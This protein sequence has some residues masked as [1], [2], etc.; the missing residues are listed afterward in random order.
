MKAFGS[1]WIVPAALVLLAAAGSPPTFRYEVVPEENTILWDD[2]EA[3]L[4]A[5]Y[6][7]RA[8]ET[9]A[10]QKP[11]TAAAYLRRVALLA[12]RAAGR[13][14][15]DAADALVSIGAQ[16]SR[17]AYDVETLSDSASRRLK[18]FASRLDNFLGGEWA[19]LEAGHRLALGDT[20][21]AG[22]FLTIAVQQMER[23]ARRTGKVRGEPFE[24]AAERIEAFLES[25]ESLE[26]ESAEQHLAALVE[27]ARKLAP[28][29]P[30]RKPTFYGAAASPYS[31]GTYSYEGE[32]SGSFYGEPTS[33]TTTPYDSQTSGSAGGFSPYGYEH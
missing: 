7:R 5:E 23:R 22:V 9:L 2:T 4:M 10:A 20:K 26:A 18:E 25:F 11:R 16:A 28:A 30:K 6:M 3:V 15:A 19:L 24:K 17:L 1:R 14:S 27:T 32:T 12:R 13:S 8:R 21:R 33:G 29:P 31:E